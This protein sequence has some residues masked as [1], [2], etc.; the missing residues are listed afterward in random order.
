[1]AL[2]TE[3]GWADGC[4][5]VWIDSGCWT[6]GAH[7]PRVLPGRSGSPSVPEAGLSTTF[8]LS[9]PPWAQL[10]VEA[11]PEPGDSSGGWPMAQWPFRT[12]G[13]DASFRPHRRWPRRRR[14]LLLANPPQTARVGQSAGAG[15]PSD[16]WH[17]RSGKWA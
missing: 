17:L 12:A 2:H 5:I 9:L 6:H 16:I 3:F 15:V 10:N 1:M 13:I 4:K 11:S 8:P 7:A 14:S